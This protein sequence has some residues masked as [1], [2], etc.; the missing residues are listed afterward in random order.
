MSQEIAALMAELDTPSFSARRSAVRRL[1]EQGVAALP[2]LV[3]ALKDRRDETRLAAVVEAL[4][5]SI[6][7][8]EQALATLGP[9][10]DP[11]VL[12]D[13]AQILG[14]RR[15]RESADA[16]VQLMRHEHDV[17][18]VTAIEA[19]GLIG[20]PRAV[21]PLLE[22]LTKEQFFRVFPAIDV[23]GRTGDPRAV[24]AL[25]PL[26]VDPLYALE[27]ARALGRTGQ[28]TAIQ[29][30]AGMLLHDNLLHVRVA[31]AALEDLRAR[32]FEQFGAVA[33]F[34]ADLRAAVGGRS[35][36]VSRIVRSWDGAECWEISAGARVLAAIGGEEAL[37]A[38]LPLL[39]G[40]TDAANAAADA[41]GALDPFPLAALERALIEGS[42]R[43][44]ALLLPRIDRSELGPAVIRTLEDDEEQVR[45]EGVKCLV[46]MARP[47]LTCALFPLLDD[48]SGLV[49]QAVLAGLLALGGPDLERDSLQGA[50][51]DRVWMRRAS[52]RILGH[53]G[54][55][56]AEAALLTALEDDD[57]QCRD[58][59]LQGLAVCGSPAAVAAI[60]ERA[61][62]GDREARAS[63][64]RA[65]GS[66]DADT[67]RSVLWR[68]LED[69]DEWVRY[70]ACRSLG[71]QRDEP[72]RDRLMV[73]LEDDA[74]QVRIAAIEATAQIG[75][76]E[77]VD[78][79]THAVL[80]PDLDVRR[81]S[82]VGLGILG[83][84]SA[85]EAIEPHLESSDPTTRLLALAAIEKTRSPR[86]LSAV[87]GMLGDPDGPVRGAAFAA[88]S[89]W[90]GREAAEML[91][92][93]VL[94]N[95]HEDRYLEALARPVDGRTEV[96]RESLV[97]ADETTAPLLTAALAR[98]PSVTASAA[99]EEL[100]QCGSRAS[101]TA[102]AAAMLAS[103]RRP[104]A[105]AVREALANEPD[106]EVRRAFDDLLSRRS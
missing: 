56:S 62:L 65:L 31:A 53:F 49:R 16:L 39:D 48:E 101:R 25:T 89:D 37:A 72:S 71:K 80:S 57:S 54:F 42:S 74:K 83:G 11:P 75:G 88:L 70:Y 98:N 2:A 4:V 51:A 67:V 40:A 19:L 27:S 29:P 10:T 20:G 93:L 8:V 79:L 61:Q 45:A 63:A 92:R 44:R 76:R 30:L 100:L 106:P 5:G 22:V 96:V 17:V 59:A 46:R 85:L 105:R 50:A 94:A 91:Q 43:A 28:P 36:I 32:C 41:L 34:D 13:V 84:P 58:I 18:A 33:R 95:P 68:A 69:E 55:P 24:P 7:D 97:D 21:P 47:S 1:A 77:A 3:A 99:L 73:H 12:A 6:G 60:V 87:I 14:R 15:R 35:R 103:G 82:L 78:R 104:A 23:L 38:L 64:A 66:I 90:P 9:E 81:A 26:L 52:L 86:S 102:A